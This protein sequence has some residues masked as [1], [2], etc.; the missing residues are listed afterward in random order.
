MTG[1]AYH[2]PAAGGEE[3]GDDRRCERSLPRQC[4]ELLIEQ[5]H[6]FPL[7]EPI[8]EAP[9]ERSQVRGGCSHHLSVARNIGKQQTR[10]PS[11]RAAR[12]VV[13]IAATLRSS[14]RLAVDP[15]VESAEFHSAVR[16]LA[17]APHLHA[18]HVFW[19]VVHS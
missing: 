19:R 16:K 8:H 18:L 17:S 10:D 15:R 7:V 11:R 12:S 14:I 6:K 1:I 13:H 2:Q 4:S 5:P 3:R 9:H